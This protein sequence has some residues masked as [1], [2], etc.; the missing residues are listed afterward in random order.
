MAAKKNPHGRMQ[1]QSE[2]L[3]DAGFTSV[4]WLRQNGWSHNRYG[5]VIVPLLWHEGDVQV[6]VCVDVTKQSSA[7]FD[8]WEGAAENALNRAKVR[9]YERG[10]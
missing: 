2:R 4:Q 6:W 10:E 3:T 1:C 7:V 8:T 5:I 9:D